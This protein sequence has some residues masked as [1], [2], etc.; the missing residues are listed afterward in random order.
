MDDMSSMYDY[1]IEQLNKDG[2][3]HGTLRTIINSAAHLSH[4]T[5]PTPQMT[6]LTRPQHNRTATNASFPVTHTGKFSVRSNNGTPTL[7][8]AVA[9]DI[10]ETLLS[11][12]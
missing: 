12:R 2:Y 1:Y 5:H 9:P 3:R 6:K 10:H 4:C 7:P 8:A 11:V